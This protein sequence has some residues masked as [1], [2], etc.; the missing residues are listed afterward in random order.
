M[1]T[2]G[3][4]AT[5]VTQSDFYKVLQPPRSQEK[6]GVLDV[7]ETASADDLALHMQDVALRLCIL[8]I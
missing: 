5:P 1:Y 6:N 2:E 4:R 8:H 7:S 3:K